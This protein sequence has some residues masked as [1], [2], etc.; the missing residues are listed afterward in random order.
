VLG[1]DGWTA[2]KSPAV[3]QR[4]CGR[5]A[6]RPWVTGALPSTC[7]FVSIG[8]TGSRVHT[9]GAGAPDVEVRR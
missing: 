8:V 5:A 3:S 2:R 6:P 1:F 4:L 7:V 9:A